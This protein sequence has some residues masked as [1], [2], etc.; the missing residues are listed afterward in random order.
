[1]LPAMGRLA[2][3]PSFSAA[4]CS[5]ADCAAPGLPDGA[6]SGLA[7]ASGGIAHVELSWVS[8]SKL[9]RT[10]GVG[11][12]RM[13]VYEDG[14]IEPLRIFDHGVVYRDPETFGEVVQVGAVGV[15]EHDQCPELRQGEPVLDLGE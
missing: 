5:D 12:E 14:G 13:V 9:R 3:G 4:A 8:P 7:C 2:F 11:S 1:M 15:G 6:F 10:V